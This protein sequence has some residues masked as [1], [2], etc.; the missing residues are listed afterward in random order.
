[1]DRI[2]WGSW[3]NEQVERQVKWE[4]EWVTDVPLKDCLI[5]SES[6]K[7]G[8]IRGEGRMGKRRKRKD[9]KE[10]QRKGTNKD[11]NGMIKWE[12]MES[13]KMKQGSKDTKEGRKNNKNERKEEKRITMNQKNEDRDERRK[14]NSKEKT[15]GA[16]KVVSPSVFSVWLPWEGTLKMD[17]RETTTRKTE[18]SYDV[19]LYKNFVSLLNV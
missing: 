5:K 9:G 4:K 17:A 18:R 6:M 19:W 16:R 11:K 8:A 12:K 15:W 14:G 1:M 3:M 2:D 10:E 7:T 13:Q